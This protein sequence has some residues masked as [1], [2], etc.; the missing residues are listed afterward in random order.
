MRAD[1]GSVNQFRNTLV[2]VYILDSMGGNGD[3]GTFSGLFG[4][5]FQMRPLPTG[6]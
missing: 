4:V 2:L 6:L 3:L 1:Q 5:Y